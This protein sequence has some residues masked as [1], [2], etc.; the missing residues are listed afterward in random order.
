MQKYKKLGMFFSAVL[1]VALFLPGQAA[2]AQE[3]G[4]RGT[5]KV[6]CSSRS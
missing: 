1:L 5:K 4:N 6:I 3:V 2:F